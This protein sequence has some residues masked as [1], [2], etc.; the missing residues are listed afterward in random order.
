MKILNTNFNLDDAIKHFNEKNKTNFTWASIGKLMN[1]ERIY[2]KKRS[3]ST[4]SA[5]E[6]Y[7]LAE[8]FNCKCE[9]LKQFFK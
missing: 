6:I 5:Q 3:G 7:A 9:D 1:N 8:I 4:W 2:N